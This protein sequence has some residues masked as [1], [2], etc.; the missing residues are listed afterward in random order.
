M[1]KSTIGPL[2]GMSCPIL[3]MLRF[4]QSSSSVLVEPIELSVSSSVCQ[5]IGKGEFMRARKLDQK[6]RLLVGILVGIVFGFL[7]SMGQQLRGQTPEPQML[8]PNLAVRK[9]AANLT[10]PISLEFLD[11]NDFLLLEKDSGKVQRVINGVVAHTALDLAVNFASERGLLG[12]ALHPKFPT[13]PGVYLYWTCRTANAP[14]DPFVPEVER[15]SSI[16]EL[17]SD[18]DDVLA[19]PLLANRVDRFVWNGVTLTFE[20]NLIMLRAFQND[21]APDPPNQGDENQPPRGNHD[22]GVITFG[23]DG[24]LYILVGDLGRRSWLQNLPSGPSETGL[25]PV[26]PDDQFGGPQ[27]DD[28]HF[29][30]A[31]LRLNDDG[32]TP[33]S[34]PF[35]R[36]GALI[37][38]EIGANIQKLFVYGIRNSFGM[39]VDPFSGHLWFQENGE[40]AFDELNRAAP[41]MNGGWIQIMGP[42]GRVAEYKQIETTALHHEDFPNLQQ[43]RWPAER[44]ADTPQEAA[45]RLFMLPGAHYRDPQFS[46]KHVLAPAAIG[47]VKG[48]A[49][50][51]Q[52]AG[53]LFV[54]FSV[55]EPLGGPLFR[56]NLT[57]NRRRIATGDTRLKDRVADN[58]DFHDLTESESLLIGRD[59]GVITDIKTGPNGNLFVI[60]LD[61]GAIYEIYSEN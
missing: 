59:F 10:T 17:G 50:G 25:G 5:E 58:L 44:I 2:E 52:F 57:A 30:G 27:A 43:F 47:F 31:I 3:T 37:G 24:K 22:G 40:D 42:L 54:G 6:K 60:S 8:H 48:R 34:N 13:N 41:G 20:R 29:G 38:G 55:P 18:T 12:I 7:V 49:L 14:A 1:P 21:Q 33:P 56:F 39:A 45:G 28:A 9:V 46:W 16:P 36:V 11:K 32:S 19:V 35:F 23:A 4:Y 15:C 53:D 51:T 26:V 61:K